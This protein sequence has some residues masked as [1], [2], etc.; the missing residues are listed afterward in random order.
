M[1]KNKKQIAI[2]LGIM[3]FLLT[4]GIVIQLNTIEHATETVGQARTENGLR[5][6]VL[7]WKEKYDTTYDNLE[8]AQKELETMRQTA[9]NNDENS[10][11]ME[12]ELSQANIMLGTTDVKGN[13]ITVN[14]EDGK[15]LIHQEDLI[16]II[17]ELKNAG[18]EA[19]SVN[20]Q[21]IVNTTFLSCDGNVILIDGNKIGTPF[22]ILAIGNSEMLY[23]AL[24]RNGGY[25]ETLQKYGI[26]TEVKKATNLKISKYNGIIDSKYMKVAE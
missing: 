9:T 19:I 20:D 3:C 24:T 12:E 11:K 2:T 15:D 10:K 22:T 7:K 5:D 6:Q 17:N 21:R 25:I 13:G 4:L 16:M 23:G 26:K 1:K 18:A 14:L 8:R